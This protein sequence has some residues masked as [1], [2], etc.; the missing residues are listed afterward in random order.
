MKNQI[1]N[2]LKS[3]Q[4]FISGQVLCEKFNVSRTAVWKAIKKLREKGYNIQSVTNKGY[5]LI[6]SP[7]ILD[8]NEI[9]SKLKT[10]FIGKNITVLETVDSTNSYLKKNAHNCPDGTVVVARKQTR[11]KGRLGRVWQTKKDQ[12]VCFSVLLRPEISPMEVSAVTPLCGLAVVKGLNDYFDFDAK[13]K[14]PNDV[15]IKNKKLCGILTEMSCEFDRVEHII[16]GIGINLLIR[17]FPKEIAYK[18]TSCCLESDREIDKNLLLAN[19][20]KS[21]E[22]VLC[23]SE[24]AFNRNNL[25]EYKKYCATL[26]REITFMRKGQEV[27][28]I[29]TDINSDGELV[30]T[31]SNGKKETVFSGEVTVQGIY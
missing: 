19:I 18:A 11:G 27:K 8:E 29:A 25:S 2:L 23:S 20:L 16:V 26:G 30:V 17:D 7:N 15:I 1:L 13:I 12:A 14:W 24:Y 10:K 6:S 4:D 28:G 21:I 22:D 9:K 31:L 5:R 3:Q